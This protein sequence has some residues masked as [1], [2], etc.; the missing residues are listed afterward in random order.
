[1]KTFF[2]LLALS[3]IMAV[4]SHAQAQSRVSKKVVASSPKV[5]GKKAAA[6]R[7]TKYFKNSRVALKGGAIKPFI[8]LASVR[9]NYTAGV[10]AGGARMGYLALHNKGMVQHRLFL[11]GEG[12]LGIGLETTGFVGASVYRLPSHSTFTE[13]P[14]L[15]FVGRGSG[16]AL[17]GASVETSIG[18]AGRSSKGWHIGLGFGAS[19]AAL[20][21]V[22][23][24]MPY[25]E[26][27]QS[28]MLT[29]MNEGSKLSKDTN[30]KLEAGNS[31]VVQS[32]LKRMKEIRSELKKL[33]S[34]LP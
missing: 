14:L 20:A 19:V 34:A 8:Q 5:V 30:Q 17:F 7:Y 9:G 15:E 11:S 29:L 16:A 21:R 24:S 10:V 27:T 25:R 32:N 3:L 1:M 18:G 23:L 26:S 33:K 28:P 6:K 2:S 31:K 22:N 12:G 4:G 13:L